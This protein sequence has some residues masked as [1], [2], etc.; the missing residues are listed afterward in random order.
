M[1]P[2]ASAPFDQAP[3]SDKTLEQFSRAFRRDAEREDLGERKAELF[4]DW[5]LAFVS[6]CARQDKNGCGAGQV[7][8]CRIGEFQVVLRGRPEITQREAIVAM[9]ALAFLFGAAEETKAALRSAGLAVKNGDGPSGTSSK[10]A[11]LSGS[12]PNGSA[13]N[14]SSPSG[15]SAGGDSTG[16]SSPGTRAREG[17]NR[18]FPGWSEEETG[19]GPAAQSEMSGD[20]AIAR[21]KS[22][23]DASSTAKAFVRAFKSQV[24][25][26]HGRASENTS[27]TLQGKM[28]GAG[29]Q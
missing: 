7:Q 25:S 12:S 11:S 28:Q 26:M 1:P 20:G 22:H 27:G 14:G 23:E 19:G 18:T 15:S 6:W 17:K 5:M 8:A 9:D 3:F 4:E 10:K 2:N 29:A 13:A 16:A 21:P 24:S